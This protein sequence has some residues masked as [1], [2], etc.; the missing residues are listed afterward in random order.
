MGRAELNRQRLLLV[1]VEEVFQIAESHFGLF[2][3]GRCGLATRLEAVGDEVSEL[4]YVRPIGPD[5]VAPLL[6]Q[7]F[8]TEAPELPAPF[9]TYL[10][11]A[12]DTQGNPLEPGGGFRGSAAAD[13]TAS[14]GS[15]RAMAI[16]MTPVTMMA[17]CGVRRCP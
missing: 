2:V 6:E 10:A 12:N 4:G 15:V 14:M 3:L 17:M 5:T 9:W 1:D 7:G 8:L 13:P 16:R 11:K